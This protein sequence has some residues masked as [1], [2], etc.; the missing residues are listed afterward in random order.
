MNRLDEMICTKM[1]KNESV[2]SYEKQHISNFVSKYS[3]PNRRCNTILASSKFIM[4]TH[5]SLTAVSVL[6]NAND[7]IVYK[8]TI[9]GNIKTE[10]K[11]K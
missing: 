3:L 11:V 6:I 4:Q 2:D 7:N 9:H 10:I 5:S 8:Q 1:T